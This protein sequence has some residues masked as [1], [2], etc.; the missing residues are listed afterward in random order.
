[1]KLQAVKKL[2]VNMPDRSVQLVPGEVLD[3]TEDQGMR[4]LQRVPNH[5]RRLPEKVSQDVVIKQ[6]FVSPIWWESFSGVLRGPA[7]LNHFIHVDGQFGLI[8]EDLYGIAWIHE[9]LLRSKQYAERHEKRTA[10]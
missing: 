8:V 6:D 4:L 5:V 3:L 9:S 10:R 1:M 7:A 2:K